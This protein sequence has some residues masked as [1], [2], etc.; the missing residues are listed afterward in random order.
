MDSRE[1][2]NTGLEVNVL[3]RVR[4]IE[5]RMKARGVEILVDP[6]KEAEMRFLPSLTSFDDRVR[7]DKKGELHWVT[8][9]DDEGNVSEGELIP[10]AKRVRKIWSDFEFLES[11]INGSAKVKKAYEPGGKMAEQTRQMTRLIVPLIR[12]Y[13]LGEVGEEDIERISEDIAGKLVVVGLDTAIKPNKV[14]IRNFMIQ[15]GRRKDTRSQFNPSSNRMFADQALARLVEETFFGRKA[16]GK[17]QTVNDEVSSKRE[18]IRFVDQEAI[19]KLA[20][21]A[22][23]RGGTAEYQRAAMSLDNFANTFL[24]DITV[25]PYK[26]SAVVAKVVINGGS[27]RDFEYDILQE[28]EVEDPERYFTGRPIYMLPGRERVSIAEFCVT[29]FDKALIKGDKVLS[30][31]KL[32]A[33]PSGLFGPRI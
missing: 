25:K 22:R 7:Y 13:Q 23:L 19:N 3:K 18:F 12:E 32:V 16:Q 8:Y 1:R 24:P 17:F 29:A 30:G 33:T 2:L 10:G 28:L 15:A 4:T 27:T 21:I 20:R 5:E 26:A 14:M 11:M 31:D 6:K 9:R